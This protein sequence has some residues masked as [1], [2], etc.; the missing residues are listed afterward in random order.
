MEYFDEAIRRF[1]DILSMY[2]LAHIY[3]YEYDNRI[4]ESIDLL[5]R[6]LSRSFYPSAN[7]LCIALIKKNKFNYEDCLQN[8]LNRTNDCLFSMICRIIEEKKL[9]NHKFFDEFYQFHKTVDYLYMHNMTYVQ[10]KEVY[11]D[12]QTQSAII[13][14]SNITDDFYQGFGTWYLNNNMNMH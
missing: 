1:D 5:T 10:S 4:E 14:G 6:S 9:M 11:K 13:R 2:N 3:I 12:V 8:L 7:L